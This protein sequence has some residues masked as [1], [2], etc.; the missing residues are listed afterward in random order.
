MGYEDFWNPYNNN[1]PYP[2]SSNNSSQNPPAT[3]RQ[4]PYAPPS[5]DPF[6]FSPGG[7][8]KPDQ[9]GDAS[10]P[11]PRNVQDMLNWGV[12]ITKNMALPNPNK[13]IDRA[14]GQNY[15]PWSNESLNN[16]YAFMKDK[17]NTGGY[18]Y[19]DYMNPEGDPRMYRALAQQG[20]ANANARTRA[21]MM[22]LRA[23]MGN[24]PSAYGLAALQSGMQGQSDLANQ[25]ANARVQ[26]MNQNRQFREGMLNRAMGLQDERRSMW[27]KQI[28]REA[29][30]AMD[31]A[32]YQRKSDI[33][34]KNRPRR[35]VLGIF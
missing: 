8:P 12:G 5:K 16:P 9:G 11:K 28:E 27:Q 35:R 31:L 24:N 29:V 30:N 3:P 15:D 21:S 20:A 25:M 33:D 19:S 26:S 22:G 17:A 13:Y 7:R 1:S 23:R 10:Q 4:S 32:A 6:G 2:G 14:V 18:D 34:K